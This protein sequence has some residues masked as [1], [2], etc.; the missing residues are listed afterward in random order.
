M[1]LIISMTKFLIVFVLGITYICSGI[2][3]WKFPPGV[4]WSWRD[5]EYGETLNMIVCVVAGILL[6]RASFVFFS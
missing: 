4:S 1:N 6:I 5:T 3:S 2:F